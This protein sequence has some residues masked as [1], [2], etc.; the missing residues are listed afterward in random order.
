MILPNGVEAWSMLPAKYIKEA[1]SNIKDYLQQQGNGLRLP[2]KAINPFE[3]EYRPELDT[4]KE[5]DAKT[6]NFYQ[7]QIGI[8]RWMV[9]IGRVDIITEGL[10]VGGAYGHAQRRAFAPGLACF[11]HTLKSITIRRWSLTQRTRPLILTISP[12][13]IG[14]TFMATSRNNCRPM[15][16]NRVAKS[17]D[18]QMFVD[19]NHA[20]DKQTQKVK[21]RI[22]HL[23][24]HGPDCMVLKEAV[25]G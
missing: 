24:E 13:T 20:G 17:V 9:E 10:H 1:I 8:L 14:R 25:D 2:S 22:S 7:S 23:F 11:L 4:T 21:D 5:L 6:A 19:S 12:S 3:T 15:H 16:Q 18:M